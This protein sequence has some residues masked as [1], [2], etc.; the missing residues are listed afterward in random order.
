[1]NNIIKIATFYRNFKKRRP[2]LYL[3]LKEHK[4]LKKFSINLRYSAYPPSIM[5]AFP[6]NITKEGFMYWYNLSDKYN[7][8]EREI[9]KEL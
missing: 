7:K 3:F 2:I 6:W 5:S 9:F 4:A 8:Y 1:M